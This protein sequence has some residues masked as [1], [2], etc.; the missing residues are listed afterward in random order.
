M[1]GSSV[2]EVGIG[3]I[4]VFLLISLILTAV[5]EAIESLYK[6]RARDL[7]QAI[8]QLLDDQDGTGLRGHLYN[9]PLVYALFP[10]GVTPTVFT[11]TGAVESRGRRNLP[12]YIPRETFALASGFSQGRPA[13]SPTAYAPGLGV[14]GR[15]G[16]EPKGVE[17]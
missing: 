10:G 5:R 16:E 11:D 15:R 13:T 3:L 12:A 8:A 2:L 14:E 17:A 6:T 9:H 4:L 1:F 7:E